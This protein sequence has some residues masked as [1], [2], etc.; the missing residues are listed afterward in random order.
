MAA[1]LATACGG[2]NPNPTT[3]PTA[4]PTPDV[5]VAGRASNGTGWVANV[6]KNGVATPLSDG[7]HNAVA[8]S[9]LVNVH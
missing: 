3:N 4:A 9:I 1:V 8:W 6:W 2:S 7:T 5:Y